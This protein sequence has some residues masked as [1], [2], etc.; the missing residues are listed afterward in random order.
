M[1][2]RIEEHGEAV[3]VSLLGDVDLAHSPTARRVLLE[4]AGRGRP[5]LV[6]LGGVTYI[7]SSG[8]ASLVEVYQLARKQGMRFA[9]VAVSEASLRVL[10]LAR[11]D[12][13]F[14]IHADLA[15]ALADGR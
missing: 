12:Q 15:A 13:V 3:V 8:I 11:L 1:E 2:H 9:L 7:D 14:P 10:K 6:D 5:L 4:W